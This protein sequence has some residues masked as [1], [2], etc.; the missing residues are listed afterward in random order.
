MPAS[1]DLIQRALADLAKLRLD[2]SFVA[3]QLEFKAPSGLNFKKTCLTPLTI[4][5]F[6]LFVAAALTHSASLALKKSPARFRLANPN[7]ALG[8]WNEATVILISG[9]HLPSKRRPQ[10]KR[11]M[12]GFIFQAEL[13]Q[14]STSFSKLWPTAA[15][16]NNSWQ[17]AS[18]DYE[19]L[20]AFAAYVRRQKIS[21]AIDDGLFRLF[22]TI[23]LRVEG[24]QFVPA[25]G[26]GPLPPEALEVIADFLSRRSLK[27]ESTDHESIGLDLG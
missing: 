16:I 27:L 26:N 12:L 20:T 4:R 13:T 1:S 7:F 18:E 21:H 5:S 9:Y 19:L 3:N 22:G 6:A 15:A 14:S 23:V 8:K 24:G 17:Q 11:F 25:H 2:F 10:Y